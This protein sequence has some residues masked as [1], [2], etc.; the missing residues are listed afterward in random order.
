MSIC[1]I[2]VCPNIPVFSWIW[3]GWSIYICIS[4][5]VLWFWFFF[6]IFRFYDVRICHID[7]IGMISQKN[8]GSLYFPTFFPIDVLWVYSLIYIY[9]S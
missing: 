5:M 3:M 1:S 7:I 8:M 9:I 2:F 4:Y 6:Q